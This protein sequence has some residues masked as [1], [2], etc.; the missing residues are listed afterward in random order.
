[1]YDIR[2]VLQLA[3][4]QLGYKEGR[5]AGRNNNDQKYS[6]QLPGF[7][8]SDG[9]P[10]CATFVQW[11]LWQAGISVPAGAR[12]ASC[13]NSYAAYKKAGRT[14]E[15][16]IVGEQIFYGARGGAHTGLVTKYDAT[17]VWAIEGNTNGDGSAEGDGV[18]LKKRRR[19]DAYVFGYGIPYYNNDVGKSADPAWHRKP[20]ER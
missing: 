14:T 10:W 3:T 1:M 17:Y 13:G 20:L 8:W 5:S 16:P 11:C 12:S 2:S 4:S 6:D 18:Y 15:Y 9:Q 7:A 19:R